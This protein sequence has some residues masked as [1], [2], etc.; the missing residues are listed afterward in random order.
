M[1]GNRITDRVRFGP[2]RGILGQM[3]EDY[4]MK[5]DKGEGKGVAPC[6][7]WQKSGRSFVIPRTCLGRC[8]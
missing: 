5:N 3:E 2:D 8:H 7:S 1:E 4:G 6:D